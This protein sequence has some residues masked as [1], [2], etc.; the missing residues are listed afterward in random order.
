MNM[1]NKLFFLL[2]AVAVS[3]LVMTPN[4]SVAA[5][6]DLDYYTVIYESKADT[7]K[8]LFNKYFMLKWVPVGGNN[9]VAD[10]VSRLHEQY[11]GIFEAA[12][13]S[14]E[15]Q[16]ME[17]NPDYYRLFVPF[18]YYE[19]PMNRYSTVTADFRMKPAETVQLDNTLLPV[20]VSA[21]TTQNRVNALVD[22]ML[23]SA[24]LNEPS[25]VK[26]TEAQI[27][28]GG[29]FADR[30]DEEQDFQV[31]SVVDLLTVEVVPQ[32]VVEEAQAE[33][34]KPNWW[35]VNANGSFQMSQNYISENWYKGGESTVA[36][37]A[38]FQ[39]TA[40]YNDNEKVQWENMLDAKL[41]IA[42]SPSDQNH[43]YL[44]NTDQLRIYSKLGL[45][46]A[47]H[48]YYTISG[49]F[50]TQIMHSYNS[51]SDVVK[52]AFLAPADINVGIG[53]D[54][55]L[56]KKNFKLSMM[57]APFTW[58]MRY[59]GSDLVSETSYG[60]D[61]GKK[62]RHNFGSELLPTL[63]WNITKNIS[64]ES[65][66]D[67]LTAYIWTRVTWE[68][69]L[70]MAVNKY[71]STKLYVHARFDDSTAPLNGDSYF[72][73]NELFSFGFNFKL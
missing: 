43:D 26:F 42:S 40:N 9:F 65:R 28:A 73:L 27:N 13:D 35:T 5:E 20:D 6:N 50:K 33:I 71:F 68:N 51:N 36:S 46:A 67:Y 25:K 21:Y 22:K 37:I 45:Q 10:T 64:L 38:T 58:T 63:N 24:Y 69:T 12:D 55:K 8:G 15:V 62:T 18:T 23:L 4:R 34:K 48:W 2:F 16:Y 30:I 29:N 3:F 52:A 57:I 47:K 72:Q 66:L 60:L 14:T 70:N 31:R 39:V 61:E 54:Y 59:I 41:G 56:E 32:E 7:L 17:S 19:S 11:F 53:M 1:R 44:V 49:E